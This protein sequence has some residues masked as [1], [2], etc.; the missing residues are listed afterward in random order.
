MSYGSKNLSSVKKQ[1]RSYVR[2]MLDFPD[3]NDPLPV[4]NSVEGVYKSAAVVTNTEP[5]SAIG[6]RILE[7]GGSAVDA[8]IA[9]LLCE[10]L[11]GMQNMGIGGGV[12]MTIYQ[13]E[14]GKAFAL[15][16]RES[17]PLAADKNMYSGDPDLA[18][19]GCLSVAVPGE[20][21]GYWEAHKRFGKLPW[22]DL[23]EPAIN[24][25][26]DG[27]PVNHRLAKA[28]SDSG[29]ARLINRS[30]TLRNLLAPN[31]NLPKVGDKLRMPS[32]AKTFIEVA[33]C[34]DGA[35]ALY[36]GVLTEKF[37]HDLKSLG[38]IITKQDLIKYQARWL[39]PI[40][41]HLKGGYTLYTMPPPGS[42]IVLSLIL[43]ILENQLNQDPK[44]NLYNIIRIVESFKYAYGFRTEL[45]DPQYMDLSKVMTQMTSEDYIKDVRR[46]VGMVSRT[47]NNCTKYGGRYFVPND[48]GTINV[49]VLAPN[50]DA[51]CA[52]STINT[53]FGSL[54][55]S[56]STGIILNNEMDDF[57]APEIVNSFGLPPSPSNFIA[58]GKRP[59]SS[60]CPS[61]IVGPNKEARL[62]V[63]AA[64]GTHITSATAQVIINNLWLQQT[65][66]QSVDIP[67]VHHQLIPMVLKFEYGIPKSVV[68]GLIKAGHKVKKQ[69]PHSSVTAI[70]QRNGGVRAIYDYRR[71]G[72]TSGI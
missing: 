31:G 33:N 38:A 58:G 11:T 1:S 72:S 27:V 18:S 8:V 62:V 57:C 14:T 46:K 68:D 30:P 43:T 59:L 23:F 42:G 7:K 20:L 71:G 10:G 40:V 56:S 67:R 12:F 39:P 36:N 60:S 54:L 48:N 52:T 15:D 26:L 16:A 45:G 64:G 35:M 25:C 9:S 61:V 51:V 3:E 69:S 21:M 65:I 32:L 63:G 4:S 24:M 13:K 22:K 2:G 34:P 66:K 6:R 29:M 5:C 44:P 53:L 17:A 37:V 19:T 70:E 41:N 55:A 50:G 49:V 28:F 47:N